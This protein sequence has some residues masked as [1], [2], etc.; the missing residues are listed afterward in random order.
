MFARTTHQNLPHF[1]CIVT[2]PSAFVPGLQLETQHI[3]CS[4]PTP[5][6]SP[7]RFLHCIRTLCTP[8]HTRSLDAAPLPQAQTT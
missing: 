3:C 6:A 4:Y 5:A 7:H 1:R 2:Q 8:A